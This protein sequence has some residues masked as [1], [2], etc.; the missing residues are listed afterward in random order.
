VERRA[1]D[2][3]PGV[4]GE[5]HDQRRDVIGIALGAHRRLARPLARL[6]EELASAGRG[7]DHACRAARQDRVR[8]HAVLGHGVG[9]RPG[10]P[11]DAGLGGRELGWP[12]APSADT[13]DMFTIRPVFC[14]RMATDAA[15][16]V[17]NAPLRWTSSTASHSVSVM[18]KI[19]RS[20]RMP[21]TCTRMSIRPQVSTTWR[22]IA[23]ASSG[24]DTEPKLAAA[25]PPS[26]TISS[27]T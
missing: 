24:S 25:L 9:G 13:D 11:E 20:R 4:A 10:E 21:A 1:G 14:S 26:F 16:F 12:G 17:L 3:G 22:T 19:I 8:G 5:E 7:V 6:L 15:R 18:L 2:A 27:A 23:L